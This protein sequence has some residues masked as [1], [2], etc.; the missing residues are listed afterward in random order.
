I[1]ET[2]SAQLTSGPHLGADR[3]LLVPGWN[4]WSSYQMVG[5]DDRSMEMRTMKNPPIVLMFASMILLSGGFDQPM[6]LSLCMVAG[7]SD[8]QQSVCGI[9]DVLWNASGYYVMDLEQGVE[10]DI[11]VSHVSSTGVFV[12]RDPSGRVVKSYEW[13]NPPYGGTGMLLEASSSGIYSLEIEGVCH[14]QV[15]RYLWMMVDEDAIA[16]TG[17]LGEK[18]SV[19]G[20]YI[21]I[22]QSGAEHPSDLVEVEVK[23]KAPEGA[24]FNL[25]EA[26]MFFTEPFPVEDRRVEDQEEALVFDNGPEGLLLFVQRASGEGEYTFTVRAY[27]AHW[28][29]LPRLAA[30]I[31]VFSLAILGI[32]VLSW[33]AGKRKG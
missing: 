21:W 19:Y 18:R 11:Q 4:N 28:K 27:T 29:A 1:D 22:F 16:L 20:Y 7:S 6:D 14:V 33:F 30:I 32:I 13:E 9:G 24:D 23:L 26:D 12:M 10:Y 3:A 15:S 25:Y 8:T 5:D 2:Y 17:V 31:V